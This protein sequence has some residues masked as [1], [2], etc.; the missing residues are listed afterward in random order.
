MTFQYR[1]APLLQLRRQE[2]DQAGASVAQADAAVHRI[3][4]QVA[5]LELKRKDLRRQSLHNRQGDVSVDG[6]LSQGRY[7]LQLE[8]DV[9]ALH[10][11]LIQLHEELERRTQSLVQAEAEVKRL[12]RL[13]DNDQQ[14]YRAEQQR[15]EQ[16]ELDDDA[17]RRFTR[18]RQLNS[19]GSETC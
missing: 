9:L 10:Q 6:L 12:E 13:R 19:N 18:Q 16:F 2:R 7:D 14:E 15:R 11:T 4:Q 3:E 17:A 1:F 5:Q 8:A